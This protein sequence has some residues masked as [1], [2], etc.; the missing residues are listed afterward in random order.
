MA[1]PLTELSGLVVNLTPSGNALPQADLC[2]P[3]WRPV[4]QLAAWRFWRSGLFCGAP[5]SA[6]RTKAGVLFQSSSLIPSRSSVS[7]AS[8]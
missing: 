1:R 8:D 2:P 4:G 3:G 7:T 6:A 5:I